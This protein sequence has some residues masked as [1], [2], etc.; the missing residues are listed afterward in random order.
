[1]YVATTNWRGLGDQQTAMQAVG[2]GSAAAGSALGVLAS[3]HVIAA[4]AVPFIGPA[5]AGATLLISA[6]IK[7]SGC[8]QTCVITS[9]WAN[10]AAD[11]LTQNLNAYFALPAPRA[12]SAQQLALK[13]FEQ[14]WQALV[15][16]CSQPNLGD[17]GKRCI[18]DRQQ[19]ACEWK[20]DDGKCFN[21][22][23]GFRDPIANDP[24]VVDDSVF[25]QQSS[26]NQSSSSALIGDSGGSLWP[27]VGIAALVGLAVSL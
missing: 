16:Q 18:S 3:T 15:Q 7:N 4:A 10:Q 6:L 11:A 12:R 13:N 9:Q 5:L 1:M 23:I 25:Q 2:Y 27:L 14:I 21:W 17:A 20:G 19:G 22:F 8:G 24:Q 26:A